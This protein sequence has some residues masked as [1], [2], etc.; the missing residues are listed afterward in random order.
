[1][2]GR[3]ADLTFAFRVKRGYGFGAEKDGLCCRNVLACYTHVHALG[4]E[5]WA[6]A[7]IRQATRFRNETSQPAG[8]GEAFL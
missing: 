1:L 4:L 2:P 3:E 6:P 7:L 8:C 5:T